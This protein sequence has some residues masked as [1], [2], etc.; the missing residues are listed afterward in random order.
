MGSTLTLGWQRLDRQRDLTY[1]AYS[2]AIPANRILYREDT[3]LDEVYLKWTARPA[4]NWTLRLT[5][6]YT[7][8]DQTGLVTEPDEALKIKTLLSYASP[9][10]WLLSGFYDYK[11]SK[12]NALYATGDLTGAGTQYQQD[13]EST[14]H[15][16]GLTL[17]V[18]A[19]ETVNTSLSLFWM[20]NDLAN[21]FLTTDT[22]RQTAEPLVT[23]ASSGVSNYKVD[24]LV[25]NLG[26]D[27]QAGEKLKMSGSYTFTKNQGDTASGAV[28]AA[29]QAATGTVD[30]RIDN[31]LH[32][33]SIGADYSLN[34]LTKLRANYIYDHY[35]DDAYSLLSGGVHT[36]V[37]EIGRAHV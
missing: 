6:S 17:N 30:A 19:R 15:M 1:G 25:L 9:K 3:E 4:Q 36:L 29:L 34:S 20:Q 13:L 7:W 2:E 11:N 21:Y 37:I 23:Y 16:A 32:S 8:A 14:F 12:N 22:V 18:L 5:P 27:W 24:S 33:L 35:D 28:L 10:G 31:T 26:A